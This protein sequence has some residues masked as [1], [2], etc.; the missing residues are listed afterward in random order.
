MISIL[1]SLASMIGPTWPRLDTEAFTGLPGEEIPTPRTLIASQFWLTPTCFIN[2]HQPCDEGFRQA[3]HRQ[4]IVDG[5]DPYPAYCLFPVNKPLTI[6][7]LVAH[8]R[9]VPLMLDA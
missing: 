8:A 6:Q 3:N 4:L 7:E 2:G 1:K 9:T 5:T